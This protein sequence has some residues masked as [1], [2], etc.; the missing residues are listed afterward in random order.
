MTSA[1]SSAIR[2]EFSRY[3]RLVE[4]GESIRITK[5]GRPIARLIPDT[6]FMSGRAAAELFRAY[7]PDDVDKAAADAISEQIAELNREA[8]DALAH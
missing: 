4:T 2:D 5:D 7:A 1:D 6:D 3:L 8:D